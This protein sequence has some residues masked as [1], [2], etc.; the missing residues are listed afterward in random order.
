[1]GNI[2]ASG[3]GDSLKV[4]KNCEKITEFTSDVV[5]T[6]KGLF[7]YKIAYNNSL[8]G[9]A[10]LAGTQDREGNILAQNKYY[11]F[12]WQIIENSETGDFFILGNHTKKS[13]TNSVAEVEI[14]VVEPAVAQ[15][16][17]DKLKAAAKS[18]GEFKKLLEQN[19]ELAKK[20]KD[21][22]K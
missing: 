17:K 4:G 8:S 19:P 2:I 9:K 15:A 20:V 7:I 11:N 3:R 21:L 6:F 1:M 12:Q 10:C 5:I 16:N 13:D 18:S 22:K 14:M